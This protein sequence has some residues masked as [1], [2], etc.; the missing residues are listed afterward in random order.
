M[1]Y[2][3]KM[4]Q[5]SGKVTKGKMMAGAKNGSY[6]ST[7]GAYGPG[8]SMGMKMGKKLGGP[9]MIGKGTNSGVVG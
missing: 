7:Y 9:K 2:G 5:S 3:K 1:A 4:A 8:K 6:G